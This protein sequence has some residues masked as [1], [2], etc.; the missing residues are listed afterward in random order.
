M[1]QIGEDILQI[2]DCMTWRKIAEKMTQNCKNVFCKCKLM[3]FLIKY[4][5]NTNVWLLF[6][7]LNAFR[8]DHM[9]QFGFL[10]LSLAFHILY[11]LSLQYVH[12]FSRL[13][14]THPPIYQ[15]PREIRNVSLDN[16]MRRYII[17]PQL[18]VKEMVG[19]LGVDFSCT[20]LRRHFIELSRRHLHETT[21][22]SG[23]PE[24]PPHPLSVLIRPLHVYNAPPPWHY[25]YSYGCAWQ[26]VFII[27]CK[28][29]N[30]SDLTLQFV[31]KRGGGDQFMC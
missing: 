17:T 25:T 22:V 29:G 21:T 10:S 16:K 24:P 7:M 15:T 9:L 1:K 5:N 12:T 31:T 27:Y 19:G 18:T 28:R 4:N 26:T 3:G 6:L 2:T 11:H 14:S 30:I 8:V 20:F 13:I 23:I